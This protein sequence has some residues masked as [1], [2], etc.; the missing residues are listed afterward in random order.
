MNQHQITLQIQLKEKDK[1]TI[2]NLICLQRTLEEVSNEIFKE[3]AW[4]IEVIDIHR[5]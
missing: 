3:C 5:G 2:L 4:S 1:S